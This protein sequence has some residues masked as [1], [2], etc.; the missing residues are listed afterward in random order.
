MA[1]NKKRVLVPN[2][3][4]AA[5]WDVLKER[6]DVEPVP[7][8]TTISASDFNALLRSDGDVNGV[9][10]GLTRFG[11]EEIGGAKGLQVV[12]RIGVGYDTV[13]VAA[14]T[15][16]RIPLMVCGTANSPSVAEQALHFMMAL[17]KRG[18]ELHALVR[19][20]RWTERHTTLPFDLIDLTGLNGWS[21]QT[22][23]DLPFPV[24]VGVA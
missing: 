24:L 13:D 12:A 6:E 9:V 2:I 1:R 14:L 10:L 21:D 22:A 23:P 5:G 3:M 20:N 11:D 15:R 17:A 16:H 18:A 19:A 7:F 4:G 8:P